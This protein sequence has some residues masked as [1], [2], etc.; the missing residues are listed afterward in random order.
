M[1]LALISDGVPLRLDDVRGHFESCVLGQP[2]ATAT[3]VDLVAV[4]KTA[5]NDPQKPL[6]SFFFVVRRASARR[7]SPRRWPSSCSA[8]ASGSSAST[9][10]R[11]PRPTPSRG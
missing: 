8:A 10:A 7:S 2:E 11:T 1:P 4:L 9:W 5:L 6:A 3:V